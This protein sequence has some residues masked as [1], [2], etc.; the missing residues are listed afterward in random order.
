MAASGERALINRAV[1][2]PI[3]SRSFARMISRFGNCKG[4]RVFLMRNILATGLLLQNELL[5]DQCGRKDQPQGQV[6]LDG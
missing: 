5:E 6:R 1:W 2:Y 4:Y 3:S